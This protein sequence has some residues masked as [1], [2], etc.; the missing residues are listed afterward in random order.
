MSNY[1]FKAGDKVYITQVIDEEEGWSNVWFASGMTPFVNN[2]KIYTIIHKE[3]TG[4]KLK[5]ITYLW[6]A[7]AFTLASK[8]KSLTKEEKVAIKCK[9]L[10]NQ[11]KYIKNN[12]KQAY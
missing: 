2:G 10:W 5:E 8:Y 11:S 1:Q 12:P 3:N 9:K 6:P 4:Y 7:S